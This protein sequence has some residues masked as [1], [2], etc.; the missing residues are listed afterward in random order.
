[1]AATERTIVRHEAPPAA[2]DWH[3]RV[4]HDHRA[5]PRLP[6]GP[7]RF[8]LR[9]L[10]R[11][12]SDM[13]GLLAEA[14]RDHGDVFTLRLFGSRPMVCFATAEAA[15]EIMRENG[16]KLGMAND[17]VQAA[18]GPENVPL[19]NGVPHGLHR[20]RLMPAF[21]G[22]ALY[23]LGPT[24]RAVIDDGLDSMPTGERVTLVP[25][26]RRVTLRVIQR[27]LFGM[28]DDAESQALADDVIRLAEEGQKP[29]ALM[30]S[31]IVP[32]PALQRVTRG[33]LTEQ[34]E[35]APE[36]A[37]MRPVSRLP[38]VHANRR[39]MD[40][41]LAHVRGVRE[42]RI[43][44][45]DDAI[46]VSMLRLAEQQGTELT[47]LALA[48]DLVTLLIA[49]HD[50]TAISFAWLSL[51]LARHPEVVRTLRYELEQAGGYASLDGT[52]TDQL[53]FL[54]AT[55]R[56]SMRLAPIAVGVGRTTLAP[57]TIG[58]VDLPADVG[59]M[60]LTEAAQR[61]PST[62]E[63]PLRFDPARLLDRRVRPEHLFPFGGGYRRCIGAHFAT[64]ELKILIAAFVERASFEVVDVDAPLGHGTKG[65]I[66]APAD[67]ALLHIRSVRPRA[68]ASG[69]G[70]MQSGAA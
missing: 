64:L 43:E 3:V 31:L 5:H 39:V 66:T 58:G 8:P 15:R 28:R 16:K 49:G 7:N 33:R 12:T 38:L 40:R 41:L 63:D 61:A 17:I 11:W 46:I 51:L 9:N 44:V 47:D 67:D 6:P 54:D 22:D 2:C 65:I 45:P 21:S 4:M 42:G 23:A 29:I 14:R 19:Q 57:I 69:F 34:G 20:R 37:W 53:P 26:A 50:T 70:S 36:R 10:Y 55:V 48:D 60:A 52:G 68:H 32:A 62:Y 18:I 56:E 59:V 13:S 24:M 1:L 35:R 27:C 25:W 30:L